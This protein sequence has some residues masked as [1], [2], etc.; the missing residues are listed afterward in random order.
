MT[1]Y[2]VVLIARNPVTGS[3][4]GVRGKQK[5]NPETLENNNKKIKIK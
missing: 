3:C 5:G 2:R 1:L 4:G